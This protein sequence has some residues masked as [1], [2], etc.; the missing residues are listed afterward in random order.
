MVFQLHREHELAALSSEE[1]VH[2]PAALD[3][4]VLAVVTGLGVLLGPCVTPNLQPQED[5]VWWHLCASSYEWWHEFV[6][7]TWQQK[8]HTSYKNWEQRWI[9]QSL[10]LEFKVL[11]LGVP[12]EQGEMSSSIG[13]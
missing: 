8:I 3:V 6:L 11:P 4:Q 13:L 10:S 7:S 12:E 1:H 5:E 9:L 2:V